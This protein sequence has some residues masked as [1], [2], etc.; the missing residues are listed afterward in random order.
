MFYDLAQ[1]VYD[2][3]T[4]LTMLYVHINMYTCSL[5]CIYIYTVFLL[6]S[7]CSCPF[8]LSSFC[9]IPHSQGELVNQIEFN[10]EH[11]ANYV[12]RATQLTGEARQYKS[13][14]RRVSDTAELS[15]TYHLATFFSIFQTLLFF[16]SLCPP[17]MSCTLHSSSGTYLL[18]CVVC[19]QYWGLYWWQ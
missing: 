17:I 19:A 16:L 2:Q 4:I 15:A 13:K 12:Q 7:S 10:V 18:S 1:L 11:T 14:N 8:F 6:S 3:V 9:H 5:C